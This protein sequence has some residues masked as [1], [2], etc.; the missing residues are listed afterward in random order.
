MSYSNQENNVEAVQAVA[1]SLIGETTPGTFYESITDSML[2]DGFMS[3]FC[4][5][6]YSGDRPDKNLAPLQRPDE[7]ILVKVVAIAQRA[8]QLITAGQ[9]QQVSFSD[10]AWARLVHFDRE[11]HNAIV[12]AGEDE[13]VRAVWNRAHLNALRVASLLAVG[14]NYIFPNVADEH[15]AWAITLV[16]HGITAFLKRIRTGEVGEGTDGGRERK[17]LD[18]CREFLTLPAGKLPDWLKE[19]DHMQA[20]GIVPRKYLQQ[21]TLRVAA[22]EKHPLKATAAL[23]MT[24]K[25]AIANGNLMAVKKDKLV[26]QFGF[27]GDAYRVLSLHE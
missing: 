5:I 27:H 11:C 23:N 19:G 1:F 17:V 12:A 24:I 10:S 7:E 9:F 14:D 20:A 3:R 21:R 18:L 8:E 6:E 13:R 2:A 25:T 16:R 15:A 22:F 26:E 4:V